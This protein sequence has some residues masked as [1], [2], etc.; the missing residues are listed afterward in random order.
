MPL[1]ARQ[2]E[3]AKPADKDYK[4]TDAQGLYLLVKK[5]GAKYWCLKYRFAGKEKKLSIGV[6][7]NI[8]L[9]QARSCRE[10][11]RRIL[12][13]GKDPSHEKQVSRRAHHDA[14][15]CTFKVI[16][17]E[18]FTHK[19]RLWTARYLDDQVARIGNTLYPA[20]GS[21]P[22]ADIKPLEVLDA[23]R[24]IEA[25]GKLEALR[26]TRQVC[27]QIFDYAIATGR[28]TSNPAT[29][30][31]TVLLPPERQ[32]NRALTDAQLAVFL[33]DLTCSTSLMALATRLL[34]LTALRSSE[35]RLGQ[36]HE[37]DLGKAVWVLPKERM[38]MRRPHVVPLSRQALAIVQQIKDLTTKRNSLYL[39]PSVSRSDRPRDRKCINDFLLQR[40]WHAHTT[41][42]GFRHVFSTLAHDNDFN[43]AWIELQLAHVD[44]NSIRGTYNHALYLDG[45]REMMQWYAD[46][47][48]KLE[49][50]KPTS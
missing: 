28:A 13:Q 11:A 36:W 2:I 37:I 21:R 7:P 45:R 43:T 22:V 38:K 20:I 16:A 31:N 10:D 6:Y 15:A 8:T 4:L 33:R 9:A 18:W 44:K 39:F 29:T 19:A 3:T 14:T 49:N 12:A 23:L 27:V 46:H 30:L 41:A 17:Q 5:S 34:M 47:L 24:T 42:H 48:D 35:L 26:K 1:T 40:G 50:E 25:Q 32:N